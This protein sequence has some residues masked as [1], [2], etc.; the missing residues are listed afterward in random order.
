MIVLSKYN[1][2]TPGHFKQI[3]TPRLSDYMFLL[4]LP[5]TEPLWSGND[6]ETLCE[7]I[8][9]TIYDAA[10]S[11]KLKYNNITSRSPQT[12]SDRWN[13]IISGHNDRS[14]WRA[15]NWNGSVLTSNNS[16]IPSDT[17]FCEHFKSPL[18]IHDPSEVEQ[19]TPRTTIYIPV[20]DDPISPVE[21][22]T[23]V[24]RSKPLESMVSPPAFFVLSLMSG[25]SYLHACSIWYS[26][27]DTH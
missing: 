9:R 11:A 23:C 7:N 1:H 13:N 3:N 25:S 6:I 17:S 14:L 27:R 16:E 10:K 2:Q 18:S 21:V 15:I 8:S 26:H 5:P 19:Y 22:D 4:N 20:L 24:R 12:A